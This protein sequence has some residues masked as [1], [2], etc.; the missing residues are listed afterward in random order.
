[1]L[2]QTSATR[3][4]I[5]VIEMLLRGYEARLFVQYLATEKMKD[6]AVGTELQKPAEALLVTLWHILLDVRA[7]RGELR[8]RLLEA[9]G[10]AT[11]Q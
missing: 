7:N 1:M 3:E 2:A 8:N 4:Q 5:Q 11:R 6:A 9:P 10:S